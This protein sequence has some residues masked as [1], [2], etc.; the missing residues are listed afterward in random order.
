MTWTTKDNDACHPQTLETL[1]RYLES[2]YSA[3]GDAAAS[4]D[5]WTCL[6]LKEDEATLGL[7]LPYLDTAQER[8]TFFW[9]TRAWVESAL[10]LLDDSLEDDWME[11]EHLRPFFPEIS[12]NTEA[13]SLAA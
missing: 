12:D 11:V 8:I 2:H 1:K 13:F 6:A 7:H 10:E 3:L 5:S 9:A 4:L